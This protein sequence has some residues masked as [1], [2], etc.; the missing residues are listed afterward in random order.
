MSH[1]W[2]MADELCHF[3]RPQGQTQQGQRDEKYFFFQR[4]MPRAH[5]VNSILILLLVGQN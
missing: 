4:F 2:M 1:E 3:S 5:L